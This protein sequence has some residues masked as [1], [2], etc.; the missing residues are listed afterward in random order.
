MDQLMRIRYYCS[1][2]TL[3]RLNQIPKIALGKR[4]RLQ[5]AVGIRLRESGS[6]Y[7]R[8]VLFDLHRP[9]STCARV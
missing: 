5:M 2:Y 4:E 3:S 6:A 9:A 8:S 1:I 7:F